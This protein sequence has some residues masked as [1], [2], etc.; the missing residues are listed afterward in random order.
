MTHAALRPTDVRTVRNMQYDAESM[1]TPSVSGVPQR[2]EIVL[3]R[4]KSAVR[5]GLVKHMLAL[6]I[7][8]RVKFMQTVPEQYREHLQRQLFGLMTSVKPTRTQS[9]STPKRYGSKRKFAGKTKATVRETLVAPVKPVERVEVLQPTRYGNEP[10]D[11]EWCAFPPFPNKQPMTGRACVSDRSVMVAGKSAYVVPT[12]DPI[13]GLKLLAEKA[14]RTAQANPAYNF[15]R[16]VSMSNSD[17][18][19]NSGRGSI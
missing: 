11:T 13:A 7:S 4:D 5:N 15:E 12:P 3:G 17:A 14:R 16:A 2:T 10:S 6:P 8:E 19:V 1:F 18:T 9:K